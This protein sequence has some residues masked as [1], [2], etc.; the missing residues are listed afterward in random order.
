MKKIL[1]LFDNNKRNFRQVVR[2]YYIIDALSRAY[3]VTLLVADNDFDYTFLPSS[4]D[5]HKF[6]VISNRHWVYKIPKL[7]ALTNIPYGLGKEDRDLL[8]SWKLALKDIEAE[9]F[10]VIFSMGSDAKCI[11]HIALDQYAVRQSKKI[12]YVH[13]PCPAMWNID[14]YAT[15]ANLFNFRLKSVFRKVF[16]RADALI[17]PSE[18]LIEWMDRKVQGISARSFVIPHI[19]SEPIT[20]GGDNNKDILSELSAF[21][22]NF[23]ISHIGDL[24]ESRKIHPFVEAMKQLI[25]EDAS[26][27]RQAVFIQLGNNLNKEP[28]DLGH[29]EKNFRFFNVRLP[30][31]TSIALLQK[32][33]LSLIIEAPGDYSP[34]M[35]GKMADILYH[36]RPVLALTPEKSEVRR[37]LGRDYPYTAQPDNVQEIYEALKKAWEKRK[38]GNLILPGAGQLK[39]YVSQANFLARFGKIIDKTH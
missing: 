31:H 37:I 32:S 27:A 19:A 16:S 14:A 38:E 1:F 33:H 28:V 17:F 34:Y 11:S 2:F 30:Y 29:F 6:K 26:F 24:Y 8:R 22:N 25:D 15:G 21:Q 36:Q 13:D 4:I 5:V 35:P 20:V 23:I 18:L 7:R 12:L 39:H 3:D 10:P 9:R